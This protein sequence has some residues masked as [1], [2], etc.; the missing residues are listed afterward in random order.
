MSLKTR[1]RISSTVNIELNN[2]LKQLSTDTRIPISR[3]LD[4]AIED[5]LKN[6]ISLQKLLNKVVFFVVFKLIYLYISIGFML[7][8]IKTL[9]SIQFSYELLMLSHKRRLYHHLNT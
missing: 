1:N 7:I 4:E 8:H 5:L 9:L 2:N 6:I 3:L